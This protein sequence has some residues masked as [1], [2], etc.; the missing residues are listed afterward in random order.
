MVVTWA[1]QAAGNITAL[2][3]GGGQ[4]VHFLFISKIL[5][6]VFDTENML[7]RLFFIS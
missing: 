5:S 2:L 3:K 1:V 6:M 4:L 7:I